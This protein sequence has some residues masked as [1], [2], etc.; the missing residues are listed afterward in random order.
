MFAFNGLITTSKNE[1][2]FVCL[3]Y[4]TKKSNKNLCLQ[5][6]AQILRHLRLGLIPLQTFLTR[7]KQHIYIKDNEQ[8]KPMIGESLRLLY[9]LDNDGLM[10][11][12]NSFVLLL[13]KKIFSYF[14]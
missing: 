5:L 8:C 10:V 6:I 3:F 12:E 13:W 4:S 2:L 7:I 11:D 1:N 14:V 9:K